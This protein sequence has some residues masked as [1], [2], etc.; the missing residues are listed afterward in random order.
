MV[1][2]WTSSGTLVDPS[3]QT[4][5]SRAEF[6]T[7]D[8]RAREFVLRDCAGESEQ[9]SVG[10]I[11]WNLLVPSDRLQ[12][13]MGSSFFGFFL[14]LGCRMSALR[15]IVPVKRRRRLRLPPT[16]RSVPKPIASANQSRNVCR[17]TT[18]HESRGSPSMQVLRERSVHG[19]NRVPSASTPLTQQLR[20]VRGAS[21]LRRTCRWR[22]CV[23]VQR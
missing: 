8:R 18:E 13:R 23:Q 22:F 14:M 17:A 5:S 19:R 9:L 21:T 7:A 16:A 20:R 15:T 3:R 1:S 2:E 12:P 6:A 11:Y 4:P 10:S